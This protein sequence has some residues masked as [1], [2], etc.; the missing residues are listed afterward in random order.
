LRAGIA[1]VSEDRKGRGLHLT[2]SAV[3]NMTLPTL[4]RHA[5]LAGARIDEAAERATTGR[6]IE[7]FSIRCARPQCRD[8]RRFPAAT[9]RSSRLRAGSKA[10]PRV[11]IVDE[12]TR[13]VD[14]G[15]KAEIYKI[16]ASLAS[17]GLACIVI[18]SELPELIG[19]AHRV[20]VMREGRL[21]GE[22]GREGLEANDCEERIV[23]MASGLGD[24]KERT[25]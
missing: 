1:Y 17:H 15:A 25:V 2:L 14:V 22:V 24:M 10:R 23:R 7:S 12:P 20:A 11:L 13:G 16:I 4:D 18:S 21:V 9:S 5:R 19:L 3:H 8:H 6:W